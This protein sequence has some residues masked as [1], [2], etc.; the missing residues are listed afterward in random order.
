M[1]KKYSYTKYAYIQL[2][3][4]YK[5]LLNHANTRN[6]LINSFNNSVTNPVF[7]SI[8]DYRKI[9]FVLWSDEK[10]K[11]GLNIDVSEI[12]VLIQPILL[13]SF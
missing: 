4:F 10:C 1:I 12:D 3:S 13:D 5:R 9:D 2:I 11:T 6:T 8:S 7:Q